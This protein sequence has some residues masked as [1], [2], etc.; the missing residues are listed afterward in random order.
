VLT[1]GRRAAQMPADGLAAYHGRGQSK[2]KPIVRQ[3]MMLTHGAV[4]DVIVQ[5]TIRRA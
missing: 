3:W 4:A 5:A 2:L 1:P